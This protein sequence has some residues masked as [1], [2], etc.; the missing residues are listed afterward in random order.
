LSYI[1][2]DLIHYGRDYDHGLPNMR[3]ITDVDTTVKLGAEWVPEQGMQSAAYCVYSFSA[4]SYDREDLLQLKW[5]IA[6]EE[7]ELLYFGLSNWE[8]DTWDWQQYD[9]A[10]T[11]ATGPLDAY[12]S[13]TDILLVAVVYLANNVDATLEWI[14]IGAMPV[15][16]AQ[17]E[18]SA[19]DGVAPV[20]LSLAGFN[21]DA[22]VGEVV[23]YEWDF[24]GDG[25][26]DSEGEL[27]FEVHSYDSVGEYTPKLRITTD[28]GEQAI[29]SASLTVVGGWEHSWGGDQEDK[30]RDCLVAGSTVIACGS[31]RSFGA[32]ITDALI[33]AYD[34]TGNFSWA[35]AWGSDEPD[36]LYEI[37]ADSVGN[38]Y[39]IGETHGFEFPGKALL[40][41][42][43]DFA[44]NPVWAK[45][46]YHEDIYLCDEFDVLGN[47]IYMLCTSTNAADNPVIAK[48]DLDG[49]F[50]WA[51]D[52]G[53][54]S[55]ESAYDLVGT[56]SDGGELQLHTICTSGSL[57][58]RG[59]LYCRFNGDG[60]L[61]QSSLW[62]SSGDDLQP[63][64]IYVSESTGKVYIVGENVNDSGEVF[65]I[66]QLSEGA[67][68]ATAWTEGAGGSAF[69][70]SVVPIEGLLTIAGS[71]NGAGL[72]MKVTANGSL[73]RAAKS[74]GTTGCAVLYSTR[75]GYDSGILAVGR[76][77]SVADPQWTNAA[78]TARYLNGSWAGKTVSVTELSGTSQVLSGTTTLVADGVHDSG[79]GDDDGYIGLLPVP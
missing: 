55:H 46:W 52:F 62:T 49:E 29:D 7:S 36:G 64:A 2:E 67:S 69:A 77:D 54:A 14:R 16:V 15:A 30:L 19:E 31:T 44:G 65:L 43:L 3:A 11:V 74:T 72:L 47:A 34:L 38:I 35:R 40:L 56:Q 57:G 45:A 78:M 26:Y 1:E 50:L 25:T 9:G 71:T 60:G 76:C 61:L 4:A 12:I 75:L 59:I 73:L 21:S 27:N 48:F 51:K 42:K 41:M 13:E 18:L 6:P 20:V 8:T 37:D 70:Q 39:A 53:S 66:E 17:L 24:D 33:A 23:N 58:S 63:E 68:I 22:G 32:G 79:G 5:Q 28:Y 10:D